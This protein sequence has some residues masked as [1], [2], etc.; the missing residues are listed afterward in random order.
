MRTWPAGLDWI[1]L[2]ELGGAY[3]HETMRDA[4]IRALDEKRAH[5]TSKPTLDQFCLLIHY[6]EGLCY[7]SPIETPFFSVDDAFQAGKRHLNEDP[8]PF[9][10][11]FVFLAIKPSERTFQ[12][13]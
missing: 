11:I 1:I 6:D 3:T 10:R 4:L 12:I 8:G 2:R 9:D 7:N 5:Y 13:Y